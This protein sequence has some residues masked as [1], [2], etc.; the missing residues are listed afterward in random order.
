[1]YQFMEYK[2]RLY[3]QTTGGDKYLASSWNDWNQELHLCV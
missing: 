1:M 3:K 2:E